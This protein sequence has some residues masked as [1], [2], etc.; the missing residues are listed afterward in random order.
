MTNAE[1]VEIMTKQEAVEVLEDKAFVFCEIEACDWECDKCHEALN[2]AI[3]ALRQ[4]PIIR[5][6]DCK[7]WHEW[8]NGTGDCHRS[9]MW[10]GTDYDDYCSCAEPKGGDE[11]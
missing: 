8:E 9:D 6:K 3:E 10:V 5:C 7:H 11:E 2:M 4:E 1:A